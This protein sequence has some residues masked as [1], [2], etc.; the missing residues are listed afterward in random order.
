MRTLPI[1]KIKVL[2][3]A[4]CWPLLLKLLNQVWDTLFKIHPIPLVGAIQNGAGDGGADK[5]RGDLS[6]VLNR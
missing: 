3:L 4:H 1:S 2:I 5:I 6:G